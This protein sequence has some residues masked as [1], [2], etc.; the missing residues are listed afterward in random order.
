MKFSVV[1]Q[2]QL[3]NYVRVA[4]LGTGCYTEGMKRPKK[5][6]RRN[7]R[8]RKASANKA[9]VHYAVQHAFEHF[10]NLRAA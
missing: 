8:R 3:V 9:F 5:S 10:K 2:E 7:L 6:A 4:A 1:F